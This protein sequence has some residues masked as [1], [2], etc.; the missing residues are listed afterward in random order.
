ML[1]VPDTGGV[2]RC[3]SQ[4]VGAFELNNIS[5]EFPVQSTAEEGEKEEKEPAADGARDDGKGEE[6][7]EERSGEEGE[8]E[9]EGTGVFPLLACLNHSC[10]PNTAVH[11]PHRSATAAAVALRDIEVR[12]RRRVP[13]CGG[14]GS[15]QAAHAGR[16]GAHHFLR[17]RGRGLC[18]EAGRP[19]VRGCGGGGAHA[20]GQRLPSPSHAGTTGSSV[21]ARSA[22]RSAPTPDA[23][24]KGV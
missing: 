9:F 5:I 3:P 7:E 24:G 21:D 13:V 10:T 20:S 11:F 4:L 6:E 18:V 1:W 8:E 17:R 2:P 16:G 22:S 14:C 12:L 15:R 23:G 19:S